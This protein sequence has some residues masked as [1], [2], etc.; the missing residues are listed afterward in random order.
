MLNPNEMTKQNYIIGHAHGYYSL[1]RELADGIYSFVRIIGSDINLVRTEYPNAVID[2]SVCGKIYVNNSSHPDVVELPNGIFKTGVY[3]GEP[4]LNCIAYA[5]M[6]WYYGL[7][8]DESERKWISIVLND[9]PATTRYIVVDG[10]VYNYYSYLSHLKWDKTMK[11]YRDMILC[12]KPLEFV[13]VKNL[14]VNGVIKNRGIIY[15]FPD[16]A[17]MVYL[18][19]KFTLPVLDGKPRQIKR[20][21]VTVTDY[22]VLDDNGIYWNVIYVKNFKIEKVNGKEWDNKDDFMGLPG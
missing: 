10:T 6:A 22:D 2:D 13:P 14:D 7:Y 11:T 17:D 5:Y 1:Y 3:R 8:A 18:G 15:K 16:V 20:R 19:T 21:L 9:D 4:I 12:R